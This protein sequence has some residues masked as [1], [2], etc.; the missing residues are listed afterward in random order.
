MLLQL[1]KGFKVDLKFKMVTLSVVA[2]SAINFRKEIASLESVASTRMC[3]MPFE[4]SLI[5][6]YFKGSYLFRLLKYGLPILL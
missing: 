3:Q 6:L 2:M 5:L 1:V 4:E